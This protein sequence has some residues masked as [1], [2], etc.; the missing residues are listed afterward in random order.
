MKIASEAEGQKENFT[1]LNVNIK[2]FAKIPKKINFYQ[3]TVKA[4]KKDVISI[5]MVWFLGS[6]KK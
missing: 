5:Y 3:K 4:H 1:Y 2:K 6:F